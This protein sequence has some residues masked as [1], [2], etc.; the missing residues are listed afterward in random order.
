[1]LLVL[2][3]RYKLLL[4]C[5]QNHKVLE[6]QLNNAF[7]I[8]LNTRK[9]ALTGCRPVE[10]PGPIKRVEDYPIRFKWVQGL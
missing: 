8:A 1:M 2:V 5:N 4:N 10:L 7:D 3:F 9:G 6:L